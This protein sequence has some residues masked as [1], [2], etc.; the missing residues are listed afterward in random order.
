[1]K[2]MKKIRVAINGFG[3]IG[4]TLFRINEQRKV[5]DIV[6]INDINPDP[7]NIAYLL[8]YDSEYGRFEKKV[9]V[10]NSCLRIGN[11]TINLFNKKN[12]ED[13][14]WRS[15]NVD[16]VIDSSGIYRNVIAAPKLLQK[17]IRKVLITHSPDT[18]KID[19]TIIL[20]VNETSYNPDKHNIISSSICD[21]VAVAPVVKII[22]ETFGLESGFLTTLHPWLSYQNLL[23]GPPFSW[24]LPGTVFHHYPVGRN[25]AKSLIP[26]PTSAIEATLKV[27]PHLKGRLNCMS[28]RIPTP[29]VGA[30]NLYLRLKQ[31]TNIKKVH[32]AFNHFA[33]KQKWPIINCMNDPLVSID[34]LGA[35]YSATLDQ[36][37]TDLAGKRHLYVVLWYDN[38]WG[39]SSH[40]LYLAEYIMRKLSKR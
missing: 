5:F 36:R 28:F 7:K 14:P 39:Y 27:L 9:T 12:I 3:R 26:K 6:A 8:Q 23:D 24:A 13:I 19:H 10:N 38:E 1:M 40:T 15:L 11:R 25:S 34:L 31:D 21:A 17:G 18:D 33:E 35:E 37:W 30:A 20:G 4:R 29:V 16:L 2:T 32:N 22:D